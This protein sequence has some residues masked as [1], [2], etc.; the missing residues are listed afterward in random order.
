MTVANNHL[1]W[2][3]IYTYPKFEKKIKKELERLEIDCFL[4]MHNVIRQ[5]SDRKKKLTLPLFPNYLF[6]RA[7]TNNRWQIQK[8]NGV[9]NFV[10]HAGKLSYVS[11]SIINSLKL[12]TLSKLEVSNEQFVEGDKVRVMNGPLIG[13]SGILV[14][15]KGRC[16]L[17]ITIET[18]RQ[19]VM[20]EV[21]AEDLEKQTELAY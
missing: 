17:A 14:K 13:L 3:V 18:M 6:V 15:R 7:D 4:P 20:V 12:A 11:D 16:K 19:S 1:D 21:D 5:W 8:V 2:Q 9:V 10:T